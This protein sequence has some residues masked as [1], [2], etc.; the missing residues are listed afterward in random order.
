MCSS[1]EVSTGN[2]SMCIGQDG[3]WLC[4]F[5]LANG[6]QPTATTAVNHAADLKA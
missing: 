2:V 5:E 3:A 6:N 1:G 4:V